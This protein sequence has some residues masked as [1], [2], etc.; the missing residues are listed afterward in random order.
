MES[1]VD[2]LEKH[3][4]EFGEIRE[5]GETLIRCPFHPDSNPSFS[6]NVDKGIWNCYGGCGSGNA[7]KLL[8][9]LGESGKMVV[10]A[11]KGVSRSK[12]KPEAVHITEE[13]LDQFPLALDNKWIHNRGFDDEDV[14]KWEMRDTG[15]GII[16]PIRDRQ[17]EVVGHVI[18]YKFPEDVGYK[19]SYSRGFNRRDNLFGI[20]KYDAQKMPDKAILVEGIFDVIR[21]HKNGCTVALGILG[22]ST[23]AGQYS[24]L[25]QLLIKE[26]FV[27]LDP[28]I[29]GFEGTMKTGEKL[30]E[31]GFNTYVPN[32]DIYQVGRRS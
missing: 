3:G 30:C 27:L 14:L 13:Y 1:L 4:I 24:L 18:R 21:T 2:I 10:G 20:D 9:L 11:S 25:K 15:V 16:L 12:A 22:S 17:K 8:T 28:D 19:Y 23:T 26:I 7:Q 29:A 6:L 32:Y 31:L 5:N